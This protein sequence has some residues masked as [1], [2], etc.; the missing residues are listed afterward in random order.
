MG[1]VWHSRQKALR[2]T[3]TLGRLRVFALRRGSGRRLRLTAPLTGSVIAPT[4]IDRPRPILLDMAKYWTRAGVAMRGV[5]LAVATEDRILADALNA[6]REH[7]P[8]VRVVEHAPRF[9]HKRPEAVVEIRNGGH[10]K[11]YAAEVKQN[12]QD[13]TIGTVLLQRT[14]IK[15]PLLLVAEYIP[16]GIAH[17]LKENDLPFIDAAGNAYIKQTG[18]FIWIKGNR[19]RMPETPGFANVP[20]RAPS[21]QPAL[22]CSSRSCA[23]RRW[24]TAHFGRLPRRLTSPMARWAR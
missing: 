14:G 22:K 13:A 3:L 20:S 7:D 23:S 1:R 2:R 10:A 19:R 17:K 4:S 9:G 6:L 15:H 24:S 21:S 16:P 18:L 8:G 5:W 12:V 11:L